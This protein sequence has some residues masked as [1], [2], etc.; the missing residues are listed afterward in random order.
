MASLTRH[1]GET[2][3]TA[4]LVYRTDCQN[5][6][7]G[8]RFDLKIT[9]QNVSRLSGT[10]ICPRCQRHGGILRPSGRLGERLFSAKLVFK[11][12]NVSDVTSH[13]EDDVLS[14]MTNWP[15]N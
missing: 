7:C 1:E 6:G 9:P 4:T 15:L 13:E 11:A 12:A 10:L 5:P 3:N 2:G 8:C 14:E